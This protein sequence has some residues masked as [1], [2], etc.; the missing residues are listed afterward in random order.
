MSNQ[1]FKGLRCLLQGHWRRNME[2]ARAT[3]MDVEGTKTN[4]REV[5][6]RSRL[7]RPCRGML[8][9]MNGTESK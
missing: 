4:R 6:D 5:R 1:L 3:V 9:R 2:R 7:S 8:G